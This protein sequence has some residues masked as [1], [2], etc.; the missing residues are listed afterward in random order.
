MEAPTPVS[1]YLHSATMVKAGVYLLARLSPALGG[2]DIWIGTVS[3]VGGAT[4]LVGGW[5]A[6]VQSDLKRVLAY[7][8][9]SA[10]GTLTLLLGLGGEP[11]VHAAM[12][13]LLGHALYKGTL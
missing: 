13:F 7:S 6:L 10:L 3:A 12:A 9:V 4:M 11:A 2:T 8:T 5:L 1:A